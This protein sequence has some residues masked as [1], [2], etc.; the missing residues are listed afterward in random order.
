[1]TMNG[2]TCTYKCVKNICYDAQNEYKVEIN[3]N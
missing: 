2:Y 1:M 3:A